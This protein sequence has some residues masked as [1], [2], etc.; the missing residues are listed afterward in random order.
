MKFIESVKSQGAV[1]PLAI[2]RIM[3]GFMLLWAFLDKMFGLGHAT[4][5]GAGMIDGGSPTHGFF[6][7]ANDTSNSW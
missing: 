3:L 5:T 7:Y 1:L 4:K 6:E 2:I